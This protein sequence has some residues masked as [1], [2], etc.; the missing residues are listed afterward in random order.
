[1]VKYPFLRRSFIGS[2]WDG[3]WQTPCKD[4]D[5]EIFQLDKK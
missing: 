5:F 4:S 1:M 3:S 2:M